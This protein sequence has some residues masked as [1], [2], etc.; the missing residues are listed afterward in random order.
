LVR[1]APPDAG[2]HTEEG[3]QARGVSALYY[4]LIAQRIAIATTPSAAT[5]ASQ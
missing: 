5:L 2:C 3:Y 1:A 4:G